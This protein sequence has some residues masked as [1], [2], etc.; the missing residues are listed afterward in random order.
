MTNYFKELRKN[1]YRNFSPKVIVAASETAE[2]IIAA[3]FIT[4]AELLMP[5]RDIKE[6]GIKI[7]ANFLD[8]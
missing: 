5:F 4:P 2:K 7:C 8:L 6:V 1:V 3:N